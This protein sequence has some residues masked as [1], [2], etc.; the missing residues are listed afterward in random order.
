MA[1]FRFA[2]FNI[3]WMVLLFGGGWN[4]WS[5]PGLPASFPGGRVGISFQPAIPDLDALRRRI[6]GA[7]RDLRARVICIQ[8][9]PPLRAQMEAFVE[10]YL[11]GRYVVHTSNANWQALHVLVDRTWAHRVEVVTPELG[12]W[13]GPRVWRQIPYYPWGRLQATDRKLHHLDRQPLI[14]RARL[15]PGRFVDLI[16]VHTKSKFSKLKT[17]AQWERRDEEAVGDALLQRAK[18]S[19]EVARLRHFLDAHLE[20][21]RTPPHVVLLGDMNDGPFHEV[22]EA[23]FYVHNILDQLTGGLL[24]PDYWFRHAIGP[25]DLRA[26]WTASFNDPV[27]DGAKVHE[28]IDHVLVSPAL[29]E[30]SAVQLVPGSCQVEHAVWRRHATGEDPP[31]R[32]ERPSDHRPVTA[33]LEY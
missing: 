30:G 15:R 27:Q 31:S 32:A 26:A 16:N 17:R 25:M 29:V 6:A 4:N 24:Y 7:I 2:T 3:E 18:L 10:H 33:E 14:V 22:L 8:E 23:E 20:D 5:A 19:A 1:R 13:Q 21:P 9:G 28:M 12:D 11:G